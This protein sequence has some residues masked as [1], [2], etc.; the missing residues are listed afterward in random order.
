MT[1]SGGQAGRARAWQ[2][3]PQL[4]VKVSADTRDAERG[5]KHAAAGQGLG[6]G[7]GSIA[8][9]AGRCGSGG[10]AVA[11]RLFSAARARWT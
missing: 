4:M 11:K 5:M 6:A 7:L 2:S 1:E 9:L 10:I 8:K 3:Q